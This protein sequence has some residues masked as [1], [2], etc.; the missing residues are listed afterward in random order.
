MSMQANVGH[1]KAEHDL[2]EVGVIPANRIEIV[3]LGVNGDKE[4]NRRLTA[5]QARSFAELLQKAADKLDAHLEE[6]K[7]QWEAYES[8]RKR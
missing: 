6:Q 1:V 2:I 5:T 7:R 4:F 8:E 3:F